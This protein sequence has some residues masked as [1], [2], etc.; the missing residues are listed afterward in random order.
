MM[1][2]EDRGGVGG[3]ER[4]GRGGDG[5]G[6]SRIAKIKIWQPYRLDTICANIPEELDVSKHGSHRW[7]Y[8]NFTNVSKIVLKIFG[9]A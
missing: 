2:E 5:R 9:G 8:S 7:C 6:L 1:G 3:E 4:K